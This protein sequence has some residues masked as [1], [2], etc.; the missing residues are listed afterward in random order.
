MPVS[1]LIQLV[2]IGQ[3]DQY[4][5]LTPQLSYFKYVYKRHTRF[6]LD[7]LKLNFDST[8]VPRLGNSENICIKK[9]ERHGDLLSNLTLVVRIPE[10]N[11]EKDYRFRWIDNYATLLIKKA[12]LFVGSQGVAINTLYGEWMVI[13][14]ELTL[15][16]E[17]K[18]KYD[19]ITENVANSLNPR[20]SNKQIRITKNNEIEY[21]YYPSNP[22]IKSKRIGI[23][24]PFYFSKNP[25]L[26]IPLCALQ[27]SEVILRIEFENVEKL[28]QVYNKD[29]DNG[30]GEAKGGYVSPLF[31]PDNITIKDF[32]KPE[33]LDLDAY[34]EAQYVYLN[35]TERKLITVNRRNNVFLVENVYKKD[36]TTNSITT[37]I[38]LDLNTPI[39]EII[40]V[41]REQNNMNNYNLRT[42]YNFENKEILKSAKILWNRS[43]ERVEEKD[44]VFFNK[45]QPYIHHSNIPKEGIYCYSFAL[46]PE[47]WQPSGYYNPGGKF[48][49]NT[50]IVLELSDE[51]RGKTFDV[52]IYA[53]Q[54][55]IFEIIGGMG[56]FKFS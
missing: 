10:I 14:N 45:I 17:K 32:V 28:Y 13:W 12:E 46:S 19:I 9:I 40:W 48:P 21:E 49:I 15:S 29:L 44:G 24:L 53:L 54:Y 52:D 38:S 51:V 20:R 25:A 4:L 47:K 33:Q 18:H 30:S 55:N 6:A 22:S 43:N 23:P 36:T 26:A 31:H 3:V 5:S 7:N 2:S 16:P 37:S 50:S 11:S 27:T 8:T 34:I 56:G 1:P 39:K 41:L 35:E 42:T